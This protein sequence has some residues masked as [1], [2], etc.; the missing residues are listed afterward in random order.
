MLLS[1]IICDVYSKIHDPT[2]QARDIQCSFVWAWSSDDKSSDDY[3]SVGYQRSQ[4]L[5]TTFILNHGK[6]FG[7]CWIKVHSEKWESQI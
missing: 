6:C 4:M 2:V 5:K 7:F 1:F 3:Y